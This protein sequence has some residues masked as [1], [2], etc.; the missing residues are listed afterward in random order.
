MVKED[1]ILAQ[2]IVSLSKNTYGNSLFHKNSP[3]YIKSN[4]RIEL[5]QKYLN[6]K[7]DVLSVIASSDQIINM[8]LNNTKN[9]DAFDISIFPKYYLYLK[10]AGIKALSLDDYIDFFYKMNNNA[11]IYDDMYF[12]SIR[13]YLNDTYKEFWDSLINFFDWNEITSSPLFSSE[14]LSISDVIKQNEYLKKDKYNLLKNI[15]ININIYDGD[16]LKLNT[17]NKSYDLIYLS[18]IIYYVD[19]NKYKELLNN[20]KLNKNGIILTYLYDSFN[21]I[22]DYFKE[23]CY[24]VNKLDNNCGLLIKKR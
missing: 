14:F 3:I 13:N 23:D 18:N 12:Y 20:F 6:N 4:E 8:I 7:K 19:I 2:K 21:Q 10:L 11:E 24:N 9:I 15:D 5:Y 1:S 17:F 22:D 16:I